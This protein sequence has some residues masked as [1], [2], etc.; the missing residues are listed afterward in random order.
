MP[1]R[2]SFAKS[3]EHKSRP[4]LR[5]LLNTLFSPSVPHTTDTPETVEFNHSST[6]NVQE[7][8]TER[9]VDDTVSSTMALEERSGR[10][11]Q[12][13]SLPGVSPVEHNPTPTSETTLS[14]AEQQ[15]VVASSPDKVEQERSPS[16][17]VLG[18]QQEPVLEVITD[19]TEQDKPVASDLTDKVEQSEQTEQADE[20]EVAEQEFPSAPP[21]DEAELHKSADGDTL[22][23]PT[24]DEAEQYQA[25]DEGT[26]TEPTPDEA[27]QHKV[28]D[29][30]ALT[31][32]PPNKAEQHQ[33]PD[34]DALTE[35]EA[36]KLS[37]EEDVAKSKS[38]ASLSEEEQDQLEGTQTQVEQDQLESEQAQVDSIHDPDSD[39]PLPILSLPASQSDQH[40]QYIYYKSR[41]ARLARRVRRQPT[42]QKAGALLLLAL[43]LGS[44]ILPL[45]ILLSY[46]I[47]LYTAYDFLNTH[48]RSGVQHLLDVQASFKQDSHKTKKD[49]NAL[50]LDPAKLA[51]A[52][53]SLA[54]ARVDFVQVQT[55]IQRTDLLQTI[56]QSFPQARPYFTTADGACQI[57]VDATSIGQHLLAAARE[58]APRL[59]G[60]LLSE[61]AEPLL[62]SSDLPLLRTT[63][64]RIQPI[65]G[66]IQ[67][68]SSTLSLNLLP[69]SASQRALLQKA[70]PLVPQVMNYLN[71]G[72]NFLDIGAWLLGVQQPRTF[73]V[74]TMDRGEIRG[75]GG[76][77]GQYGELHINGG[78]IAPF[79][80]TNVALLEYA[81]N[82]PSYGQQA[83][84]AYRSWWPFANW[85]LRDANLSADFPTTAALVMDRYQAEVGTSV[86][87][88][89]MFTPTLIEQVL[90]VTGPLSIPSYQETITAQNLEDKL[91]YY[92]LN[93]DAIRKVKEKEHID[94]DEQA[95]K[96]FTSL[97]SH[98]LMDRVRQSSPNELLSLGPLL[99]QD[100]QTRDLQMYFK[101]SQLEEQLSQYNLA[102]K[103]D[104][105]TTRDGLYI[106]QMN[107]GVN[108]A[109]QY[110]Q[111]TI[112]DT[113]TL[114]TTGDVNH[115]LQ[116]HFV[117]DQKGPVYGY[118]TY[119]DY[120]RVYVPANATF[121]S[122]DG[123]D[124]GP[125]HP[126]CG[127]PLGP[128]PETNVYPQNQLTC[129]PGQYAAGLSDAYLHDPYSASDHPLD[130]IGP[131]TNFVSDEP[132]RAMFAGYVVIP[133]NCSLTLTLS[134][135]VPAQSQQPYTLLVQRQAGTYPTLNLNVV[136]T[137]STCSYGS[138][139][140][141][142]GVMQRDLTF[143][144]QADHKSVCT[145]Q[146]KT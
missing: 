135:S 20:A 89:I 127:G 103:L 130:E 19:E 106:V 91:H 8:P 112:Q 45:A 80:L 31:E 59:R 28:M 10:L 81:A 68:R 21:P 84:E 118:D 64:Q 2:S 121:R 51:S 129:P 41:R 82:S 144:L 136:P 128:C 40:N 111:N 145:L 13:E 146:H 140:G 67:A 4:F 78:R 46:G 3:A 57:A 83:P 55:Y 101:Q 69:I 73:L 52:D 63:L 110:V 22:T 119:R 48:A 11:E 47:R 36:H 109:A 60:S 122:G 54:A 15:A 62:L 141:F 29:D 123:F 104:R 97:V 96:F 86:D 30:G 37:L 42:A 23:R 56:N 131:P 100:L 133:K 88:V 38:K 120:V 90:Q 99:L 58:L 114:D 77:N 94:D 6:Q 70:L 33:V 17:T 75:T 34:G 107:V 9:K 132:G 98:A 113:V 87:G 92:Q 53:K 79:S 115:N 71:M 66:D 18:E 43:L 125:Y 27:E 143:T 61:S 126:L 76:F 12:H 32:P 74:E 142:N 85:G 14:E 134:W 116:M 44:C 138:Q 25:P 105:S 1:I 72:Q 5:T 50:M 139:T 16:E 108:K 95:R 124:Q 26:L 35:S 49:P 117:Y 7:L 93:H 65:I 137:A 102:G 39:T 24:P